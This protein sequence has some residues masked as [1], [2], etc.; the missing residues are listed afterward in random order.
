MPASYPGSIKNFGAD[1]VDGEYIPASDMNGVRAEV[2]AIETAL[3]P[4]IAI[5]KGGTGQASKALAFG[6]LS[7]LAT[8]GDLLGFDTDNSILPVGALG[9]VL[10]ADSAVALGMAWKAGQYRLTRIFMVTSGVAFVPTAGTKALY[11]ECFG[12]GGAG[13]GA[14][15]SSATLSMGGGGG[16]GG[17]AAKWITGTIKA[18]YTVAIGAGGAG[19]SGTTGGAGGLTSFDSPSICT[20]PGGGGGPVLAAAATVGIVAGG[21][22]AVYSSGVGDIRLDS[23]DGGWGI[24]LSGTVGKAGSGGGAPL[25]GGLTSGAGALGAGVAGGVAGGG[26]SGAL[27]TGAVQIGGAGAA[28]CIRVWGFA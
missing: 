8:K 10:V 26:G 24:R 17:Y 25:G 9:S 11:V 4:P 15:L 27:T 19:V 1:R 21:S 20:A 23:S 3:L 5:A 7:P 18:S 16:A 12:G 13:G 6:A 14:A 2:V 22:G 28:G